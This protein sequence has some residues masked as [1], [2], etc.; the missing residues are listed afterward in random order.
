MMKKGLLVGIV[1]T[2]ISLGSI[3][4][5]NEKSTFTTKSVNY[6]GNNL[7][8]S[9]DGVASNTLP[10]DGTYYLADYDCSS[11]NTIVSWDNTNYELNVSNGKRKG[12]VSCNLDFQ[13]YPSLSSMP[14]GSYVSYVGDN[15]C[16]DKTCEGQNANYVSDTDMGYCDSANYKYTNNG[17]RIGYVEN[18][19]V[20]LVSAGAT[21]CMCTGSN[22]I[23]SGSSCNDYIMSASNISVHLDNLDEVALKYCNKAFAKGGLCNVSNSWAMDALDFEKMTGSALNASSCYGTYSSRECGYAN[24][25]IDNGGYY[26]L[27]STDA[28]LAHGAFSWVADARRIIGD[29]SNSTYGVRPIIALE[30][31]VV[32]TGGM[33]TYEEP[34]TIENN[35]FWINDG[36]SE[37]VDAA[38]GEIILTLT[39]PSATKMCIS[40][41]TSVCTNYIDFEERY[42]LDWSSEEPGEKLV[43]VYYKNDNGSVIATI[44]RSITLLDT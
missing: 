10:T 5:F 24:D 22:G 11:A 40:T 35:T 6:N 43:Y 8:I 3:F 15:G 36:A 4:I 34:Y 18:G 20:Y 1:I 13:T 16:K 23:S 37:V 26:W 44:N 29:I 21:E 42:I 27:A 7:R 39:S 32:V 14:V 30:S 19:S 9:I 28:S 31:M 41:N 12:G 38:K 17:W 33:G 25:L 2:V